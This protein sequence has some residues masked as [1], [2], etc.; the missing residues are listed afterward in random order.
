MWAFICMPQMVSPNEFSNTHLRHKDNRE[1]KK[2]DLNKTYLLQKQETKKKPKM[3]RA[4][5]KRTLLSQ[6]E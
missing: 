1:Y 6:T 5:N 3:V 4:S 2:S